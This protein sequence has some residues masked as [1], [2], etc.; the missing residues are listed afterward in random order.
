MNANAKPYSRPYGSRKKNLVS[1]NDRVRCG[2]IA[3][4]LPG[5]LRQY[6]GEQMLKRKN[7]R[8]P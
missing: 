1:S 3:D 6:A 2:F 8:K 5:I 4:D 7:R